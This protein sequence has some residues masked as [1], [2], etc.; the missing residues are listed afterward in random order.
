MYLT[1]DAY[2]MVT[3]VYAD[4][5]HT[6]PVMEIAYDDKGYRLKKRTFDESGDPVSDTWYVRDAGGN[7]LSIYVTDAAASTTSQTEVP[8]YAAGRR[9][10]PAGIRGFIVYL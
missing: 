9:H 4:A 7:I 5:A 2:G 6:T 8:I 3:G 1:Y 10:V